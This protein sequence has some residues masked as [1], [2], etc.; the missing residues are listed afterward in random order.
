[1]GV[2]YQYAHIAHILCEYA[3]DTRKW[4]LLLFWNWPVNTLSMILTKIALHS[5]WWLAKC[6]KP[7]HITQE[8]HRD[9]VYI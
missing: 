8:V 4:Q 6:A 1:V 7:V 5:S 3:H 9:K 2:N